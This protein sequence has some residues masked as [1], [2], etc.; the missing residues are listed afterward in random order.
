M[1][2]LDESVVLAEARFGALA[3]GYAP[4][5]VVEEGTG[6]CGHKPH[7]PLLTL[8]ERKT[9]AA[10]PWLAGLPP[11][12]AADVL[13]HCRV[14][15]L[16]ARDC[17][18]LTGH[19]PALCGVASGALSVRLRRPH[20]EVLDYVPAGSWIVD[21]GRTAASGSLL[22]LEAHRRATVVTLSSDGLAELARHC[23]GLQ[24]S[25]LEIG[26]AFMARLMAILEELSTLPLRARIA[27]SLLR[28]CDSFGAD[29]EEGTRVM[30]AINQ[31]DM[32]LMLRASRQ[33]LNLELK[34]LESEGVLRVEKELLV[35]DRRALE[36]AA[37][38]G[39][40]ALMDLLARAKGPGA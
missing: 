22:L 18:Y 31:T 16:R 14:R 15:N 26:W 17:V 9:L 24:Q 7:E 8:A 12:V 36:A 38:T 33:R 25:V 4:D 13:Q 10:A 30:L 6:S 3:G 19:G 35:L 37:P 28:L 29:E 21:A 34:S 40:G 23:G 27:R 39:A 2:A 20:S 32:A 11:W 1:S 5:V